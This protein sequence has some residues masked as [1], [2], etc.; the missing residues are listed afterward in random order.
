MG[1]RTCGDPDHGSDENRRGECASAGCADKDVDDC[2]PQW[3]LSLPTAGRS[4]ELS[5]VMRAIGTCAPARILVGRWWSWGGGER[6]RAGWV[7][8]VFCCRY[9]RRGC[10]RR[11]SRRGRGCRGLRFLVAA[12]C[13]GDCAHRDDREDAGEGRQASLQ[14][15]GTHRALLSRGSGEPLLVLSII[16]ASPRCFSRTQKWDG[17]DDNPSR[18]TGRHGS[19]IQQGRKRPRLRSFRTSQNQCCC[20]ATLSKTGLR[21]GQ[22]ES[23]AAPRNCHC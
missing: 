12:A 17:A 18:M 4:P 15:C 11:R 19:D 22:Y 14:W 20:A 7:D 2:H 8:L 1:S 5:P 10:R 23:R 21:S 6:I 3:P 9:W 13:C 16:A